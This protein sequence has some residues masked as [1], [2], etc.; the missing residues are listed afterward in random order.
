MLERV[1][2]TVIGKGLAESIDIRLGERL[3]LDASSQAGPQATGLIVVGLVD[4]GIEL[5]DETTV[6][7]HI[8]DA[9]GLTGVE[10]ATGVRPRHPVRPGGG[11]PPAPSR[12]GSLKGCRPI[13]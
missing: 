7:I 8:E 3:A 9:R 2:E 4:S 5:V 12:T 1:G 6:L 10:T 13:L 11:R